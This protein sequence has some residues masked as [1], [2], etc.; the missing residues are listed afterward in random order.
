MKRAIIFITTF[1]LWLLLTWSLNWQHIVIGLA[2]ALI[3]AMVFGKSVIKNPHKYV[4]VGR[5]FW[6]LC[7]IPVFIWECIKSNFDVAYRVLHP[8][9]PINPGIVKVKTNLTS[10]MGRTFLANSI[11]MTPGTLTVDID[12][13]GGYLYIHWINIKATEVEEASKKIVA[14]FEKFLIKM[15]D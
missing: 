14:K 9:M 10:E 5:Y 2:A 1:I 15:F 13:E 11:T 3:I 8:K 12:E 7:Y 4:E 6:G